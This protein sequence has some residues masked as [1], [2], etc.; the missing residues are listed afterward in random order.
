MKRLTVPLFG[1]TLKEEKQPDVYK[2][3]LDVLMKTP[4]RFIEHNKVF[5][6]KRLGVLPE[7][8]RPFRKDIKKGNLPRLPIFINL[9]SNTMKNTVQRYGF[10]VI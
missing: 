1:Q 3:Q 5:R 2:K 6:W 8:T 4:R 10:Y 7:T 9:K